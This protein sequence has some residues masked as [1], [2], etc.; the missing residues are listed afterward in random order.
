MREI[1]VQPPASLCILTGTPKVN[2]SSISLRLTS[3][4]SFEV[5]GNRTKTWHPCPLPEGDTGFL[6]MNA[7]ARPGFPSPTLPRVVGIGRVALPPSYCWLGPLPPSASIRLDLFSDIT[8]LVGQL[9]ILFATSV[10]HGSTNLTNLSTCLSINLGTRKNVL[11][12]LPEILLL[13]AMSCRHRP[14]YQRPAQHPAQRPA[15]RPAG[16]DTSGRCRCGLSEREAKARPRTP[17]SLFL[18]SASLF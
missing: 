9:N 3:T 15:Q 12:I 2:M 10:S 6:S 11:H 17:F 1:H 13:G 14:G 7:D 5:R 4:A 16:P 18:L 8:S